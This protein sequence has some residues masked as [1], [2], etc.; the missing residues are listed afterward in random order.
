MTNTLNHPRL[1]NNIL[2]RQAGEL[3]QI[4]QKL[5]QLQLLQQKLDHCIPDT[6]KP[7]CRV[8]N[9]RDG[10]LIIA[11]SSAAWATQLRYAI[12]DLLQLL[13]TQAELYDLCSINTYIDPNLQQI[14]TKKES[15]INQKDKLK[16]SVDIALYLRE[17]AESFDDEKLK[18]SFLRLS[19]N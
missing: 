2:N 15:A 17:M 16:L 8:A 18:A 5:Q 10:C 19:K 1:V 3:R 12:P 13:R 9:Y 6:F 11:V 14:K 4:Q 7:Y